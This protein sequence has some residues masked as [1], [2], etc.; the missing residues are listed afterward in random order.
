MTNR[1]VRGEAFTI[2]Q[3]REVW[4]KGTAITSYDP[5]AYRQDIAG[6]WMAWDKYGDT[7][8][9]L[10]LGWEI[11]HR[12]PLSKDGLDDMPNLRPLQWANNRSKGDNLPKWSSAVSSDGNNNIKR[13]Q[14]WNIEE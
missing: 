14:T 10:G 12:K 11:D 8:S 6:A 2:D 3:R 5:N 4:K 7:S 1:N 13:N 9:D